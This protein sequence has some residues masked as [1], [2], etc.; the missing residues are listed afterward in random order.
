MLPMMFPCILISCCI[1]STAP[2]LSERSR[3]RRD[4]EGGQAHAEGKL[5]LQRLP[6]TGTDSAQDGRDEYDQADAWWVGDNV[7]CR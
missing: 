5:R 4:E 1:I 2:I 7:M 3:C 6:R